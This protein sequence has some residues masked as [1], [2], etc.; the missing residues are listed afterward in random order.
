VV[1]VATEVV[2]SL[3][4]EVDVEVSSGGVG[5]GPRGVDEPVHPHSKTTNMTGRQAP[6]MAGW[7][8]R[9][10]PPKTRI[11]VCW[12]RLKAVGEDWG[13]MS[14]N[15]H[16]TP[17]SVVLVRS[18]LVGALTGVI[19]GALIFFFFGFIG[20]EGA[21]LPTRL[22]NGWAAAL[23]PG[24]R[25]G[26]AAG[27][28]IAVGLAVAY[29]L[30][31]VVG[32]RLNPSRTRGWLSLLAAASVVASNLESLR[33]SFGWDAVGTATVLGIALLVSF[34][35]WA[36]TPWVLGGGANRRS[37]RDGTLADEGLQNG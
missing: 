28:A 22:E 7:L 25:R 13:E 23:S 35:V 36:V 1:V 9:F 14:S 29:F 26:L 3:G 17:W 15:H 2:V 32:G 5:P 6:C 12:F 19:G 21:T 8:P 37:L 27:L 31:S 33:T 18:V 30:W 20:F 34:I 11:D 4:A 10:A 16:W 24:L